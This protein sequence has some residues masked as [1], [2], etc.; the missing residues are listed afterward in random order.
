MNILELAKQI[1]NKISIKKEDLEITLD[2]Y[3]EQIVTRKKR[4]NDV[5]IEDLYFD[6]YENSFLEK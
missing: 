5:R 3:S 1:Q 2:L 6:Y 4:Y